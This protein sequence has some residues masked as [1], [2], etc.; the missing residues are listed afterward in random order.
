MTTAAIVGLRAEQARALVLFDSLNADEWALPSACSGWRV[1]DVVQHMASTFHVIA[2]PT[3]VPSGSDHDAEVNAE[4]PVQARKDWSADQVLEEYREWSDK[5]V[6][7]L[8][9]MQE[10]PLAQTVAPFGN[11]GEH[12]L[13]ILGNAIAFD[14]YCHLR[15][16]IGAAIPRFADLPRDPAVLEP[17]IEWMLAG[18]PQMCAA[19]LAPLDQGVNFVFTDLRHAIHHLRPTT[20]GQL[21][22]TGAGADPSYGLCLTSAHDFVNW[23]TKRSDWR[24]S[25]TL[26]DAAATSTLDA[27]NVI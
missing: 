12:P 8:S 23:A 17:T 21:W 26:T 7:A 24:G 5:G 22:V 11:L 27:I 9:A 18:V 14:H 6:A 2:D 15:H 1:Q 3:T 16:D 4:V 20:P 13:H 10:A 19:A 25:A